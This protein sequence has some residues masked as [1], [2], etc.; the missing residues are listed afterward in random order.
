MLPTI[1]LNPLKSISTLFKS[2]IPTI[3]KFEI[4]E[5]TKKQ[6]WDIKFNDLGIFSYNSF[7]FFIDLKDGFHSIKWAD[8]E[9]MQAYKV[10]LLTIDEICIDITFDNKTIIITEETK[11]WY[12]FI[13]KLKSAFTLKNNNWETLV[14][15]NAFEYNFT[16]IYE[17]EDRKMPLKS[18]FYSIIKGKAKEDINYAFQKQGWTIRKF[19]ITDFE[20]QNS[21]TELI[22]QSSEESLLLHG[23]V[24]YHPDNVKIIKQI[25]ESLEC[26]YK[27][28]FYVNDEIVEEYQKGL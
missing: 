15:K 9:R 16:I 3:G 27:F 10:D 6:N 17:R 2:K 23:L 25:F 24:A 4:S 13:E 19:S 21:W 26:S 14:L 5:E 7:G 8:I 18:N 28:E 20:I 1:Y 12:Q 11:G 22:L